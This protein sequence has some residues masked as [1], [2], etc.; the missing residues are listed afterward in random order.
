MQIYFISRNLFKFKEVEQ[1]FSDTNIKII[2]IEKQISEIQTDNV[3]NLI[4]QKLLFAFKYV[5]NPVFVEHTCLY[6]DSL[7]G[8]PGG[9]TQVFWDKLG[10]DNFSRL[11]SELMPNKVTAKTFIGYC[12]GMKIHIFTGEI[13][14]TISHS[15]KGCRDF[16]WDCIF[17]PDGFSQTF[18]ELGDNKN[19]ISMR[20][21]AFDQLKSFLLQGK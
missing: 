5:G 20:K 1:I 13:Q 17:I 11:F 10:A 18:A 8:L 16:Q 9:L 14:G 12:D 21:K 2:Q 3:E 4:K 7:N 15:P 6:L 19:K